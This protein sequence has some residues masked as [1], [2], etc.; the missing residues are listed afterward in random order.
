M[1]HDSNLMN[2]PETPQGSD[3]S[4][5]PMQSLN[6]FLVSDT[7]T[8]NVGSILAN[9]GSL[10]TLCVGTTYYLVG[11]YSLDNVCTNTPAFSVTMRLDVNV[12][13]SNTGLDGSYNIMLPPSTS[14]AAGYPPLLLLLNLRLPFAYHPQ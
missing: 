14:A 2:I 8:I 6:L 7:A 3:F 10:P 1:H 12:I 11:N 13:Y 4:F 5:S 9:G